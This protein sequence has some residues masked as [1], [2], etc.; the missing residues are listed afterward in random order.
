LVVENERLK[1]EAGIAQAGAMRI[2]FAR[3]IARIL[4]F[5]Y[6]HVL[7][8]GAPFPLWNKLA[9]TDAKPHIFQPKSNYCIF[10]KPFEYLVIY[11]HIIG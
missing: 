1:Y 8:N 11:T 2:C 9:L 7:S 4:A 10:D 6:S 5:Q 3:I